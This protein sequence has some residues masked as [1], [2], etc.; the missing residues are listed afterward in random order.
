MQIIDTLIKARHVATPAQIES[1]AH[2]YYESS[3]V[4]AKADGTYLKCVL[5]AMQAKLGTSKRGKPPT[6]TT[7]LEVLETVHA[8]FYEAVLKGVTTPEVEDTPGLDPDEVRLRAAERNR[9]SNFARSAKATVAYFIQGG[10]NVRTLDAGTTSKTA[11]RAAVS[12][13]ESPDQTV[14]Q[15]ARAQA[16]ILRVVKR[17]AKDDQGAA[18]DLLHAAI[19]ALQAELE[20][21]EVKPQT[22]TVTRTAR[23]SVRAPAQLHRGA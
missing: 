10:G 15:V 12:P 2:E 13:P 17:V 1:L 21:L 6:A 5:V 3:S 18:Y 16:S 9:R 8:P 22:T 19:T 7:Q 20:G 14:R 23:S 11:L 4:T